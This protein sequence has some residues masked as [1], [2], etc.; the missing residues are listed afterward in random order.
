MSA[1][2]AALLRDAYGIPDLSGLWWMDLARCAE[3]DGELFFVEKGGSTAPAKRICAACEVREA[4]LEYALERGINAGV[5]GGLSERERRRLGHQR[6][7]TGAA[8]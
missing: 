5:W 7:G 1:D 4:C 8:A 3:V 6:A 2:L